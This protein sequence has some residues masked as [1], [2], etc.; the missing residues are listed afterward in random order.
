MLSII[1][2]Y[3]FMATIY[4]SYYGYFQ[5][6]E[7]KVIPNWFHKHDSDFCVLLWPPQAPDLNPEQLLD[8]VEWEVL[9]SNVS[10][11]NM[12]QLRNEIMLTW[13]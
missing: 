10:L 2:D 11:I 9:S 13:T 4:P 5:H 1:A 7:Q 12:Q 8:V 6:D 3:R